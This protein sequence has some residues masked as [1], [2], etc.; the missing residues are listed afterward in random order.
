LL[1]NLASLTGKEEPTRSRSV[2]RQSWQR[3]LK[4]HWG[5]KLMCTS[6]KS[7]DILEV[8]KVLNCA[9]KIWDLFLETDSKDKGHLRRFCWVYVGGP[10]VLRGT[11]DTFDGFPSEVLLF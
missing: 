11:S 1:G 2:K 5:Q 7:T 6:K 4:K 9:S 3:Y 10:D 8:V